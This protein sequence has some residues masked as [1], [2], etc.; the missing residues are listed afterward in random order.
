MGNMNTTCVL[1]NENK[2]I[3]SWEN[4]GHIGMN[5]K[6]LYYMEAGK[7]YYIYVNVCG[8]ATG[9]YKLYVEKPFSVIIE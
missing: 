6:L 7:T 9:E 5:F 2:E 3:I 8:N 4:D 1:Y